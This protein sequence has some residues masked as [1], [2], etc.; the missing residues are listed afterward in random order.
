MISK[1]H[2]N[3]NTIKNG[4]SRKMCA[5]KQLHEHNLVNNDKIKKIYK[6]NETKLHRYTFLQLSGKWKHL[7]GHIL[8]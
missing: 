6:Q 4:H 8:I 5:L 7:D 2:S 1:P 3:E